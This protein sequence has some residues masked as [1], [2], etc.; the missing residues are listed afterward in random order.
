M[1]IWVISELFTDKLS[2]WAKKTPYHIRSSQGMN[3]WMMSRES[4]FWLVRTWMWLVAVWMRTMMYCCYPVCCSQLALNSCILAGRLVHC[5]A[6][7][8]FCCLI[9]VWFEKDNHAHSD[10]NFIKLMQ[11]PLL[12]GV[13]CKLFGRRRERF[14]NCC[15]WGHKHVPCRHRS[16][17]TVYWH[18]FCVGREDTIIWR[19]QICVVRV[20]SHL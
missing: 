19:T 5:F 1:C 6:L 2:M 7:V 3:V 8:W 17:Q 18:V 13:Y 10:I 4:S 16:F 15:C 20:L 14:C 12:V 9:V 11:P